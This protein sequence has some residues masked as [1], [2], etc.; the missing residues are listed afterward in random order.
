MQDTATIHFRGA[1]TD[2][3]GLVP[4]AF[5]DVV[6]V[7][8]PLLYMSMPQSKNQGEPFSAQVESA[9]QSAT[10]L[11]FSLPETPPGTYEAMTLIGTNRYATVIEVVARPL[12]VVSPSHLSLQSSPGSETDADLSIVN[13]GNVTCDIPKALKLG[14]LDQRG[15]ERA[16]GM[17]LREHAKDGYER[18][19][20]FTEELANSHSGQVSVVVQEG[21]GPLG[22]GE[23]RRLRI[24]LR[25]PDRLKAGQLYSGTLMLLNLSYY[26]EIQVISEAAY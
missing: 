26:I 13:A 25:V 15:P 17:A 11:R 12:L 24:S 3:E 22:P 6:S 5:Q 10:L 18:I 8:L 20:R 21:S 2:I 7:G 14:L 16:F 4:I 9:G 19:N 23:L 1:P